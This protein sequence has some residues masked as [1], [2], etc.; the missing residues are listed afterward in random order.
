MMGFLTCDSY[1]LSR[2]PKLVLLGGS[3]SEPFSCLHWMTNGV[4]L[5]ASSDEA[6]TGTTAAGIT[7]TLDELT[8]IDTCQYCNAH[9]LLNF[10]APDLPN[11]YLCSRCP[12]CFGGSAAAA[13]GLQVDCIVSLDPNFQ[14]KQIQDYDQCAAFRGQK[15]PGSQDPKMT[16]PLCHGMSK[17]GSILDVQ[18]PVQEL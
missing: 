18:V 1:I 10:V 13:L 2:W 15:L 5:S 7:L 6:A 12:C 16:S 4:H 3:C 9:D 11:D 17:T 8:P 14:L